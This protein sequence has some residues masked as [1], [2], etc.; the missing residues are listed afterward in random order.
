MF[1]YA[2]VASNAVIADMT[3]NKGTNKITKIETNLFMNNHPLTLSFL[4]FQNRGPLQYS[5][6]YNSYR[7][8][9]PLEIV[10]VLGIVAVLAAVPGS[11]RKYL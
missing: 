9:L 2:T 1:V 4:S 8:Q 3:I 10:D 5:D 6:G 7:Q 11:W